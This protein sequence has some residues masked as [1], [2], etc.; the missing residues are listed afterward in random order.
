MVPKETNNRNNPTRLES[1][2]VVSSR[3]ARFTLVELL[4]VVAII[5]ILAALLLPALARARERAI[6]VVCLSDKRQVG[7]ATLTY[8]ADSDYFFPHR[9]VGFWE[10]TYYGT[11]TQTP[12]TD[13]PLIPQASNRT[14]QTW[15]RF[16]NNLLASFGTVYPL[17]T[18]MLMGYVDKWDTLFCS[19][20]NLIMG[21]PYYN[22]AGGWYYT[23]NRDTLIKRHYWGW[24][25]NYVGSG[26]AEFF[27]VS[28]YSNPDPN[29]YHPTDPTY[30][31]LNKSRLNYFADYWNQRPPW[32]GSGAPERG[33]FS[34][35]LLSCSQFQYAGPSAWA[36]RAHNME[37]VNAFMVD[38][39]ARWVGSEE[40]GSKVPPSGWG[41][42]VATFYPLWNG[43]GEAPFVHYARS[44]MTIDR[45]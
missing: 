13:K 35:A 36:N 8:C 24:P 45:P 25:S 27:H 14:F 32:A 1:P 2:S 44:Y 37:G 30:S 20:L 40:I 41:S 12:Y 7:I 9:I 16:S 19:G 10:P 34:P 22:D 4:V 33:Y 23:S 29:P 3:I 39:S 42:Q 26:T 31:W 11:Y 38:G 5:A 43:G 6:R 28:T 21:S 17:G 18:L 15:Q